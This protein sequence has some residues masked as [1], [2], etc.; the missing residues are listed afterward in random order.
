MDMNLIQLSEPSF[1]PIN[2]NNWRSTIFE[3]EL[4]QAATGWR[5]EES[6]LH[7]RHGREILSS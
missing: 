1:S 6:G 7:F 2:W 5:T 3:F 4:A